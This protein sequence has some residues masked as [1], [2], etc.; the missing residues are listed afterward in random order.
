[1]QNL[2]QGLDCGEADA[3]AGKR[4]G[5][6]NNDEGANVG[7]AESVPL[8]EPCDLRHELRGEGAARERRNFDQMDFVGAGTFTRK[9]QCNGAVPAG[10][11]GDE[12]KHLSA[13]RFI[14]GNP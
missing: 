2:G 8:Q 7:F 12:K 3:Q 13:F 5:P 1:L 6:R 11:I 4:T 9:R 10:S 14:R